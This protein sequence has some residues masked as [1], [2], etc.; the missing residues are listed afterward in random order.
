MSL[1]DTKP[2]VRQH[3]RTRRRAANQ[4][5]GAFEEAARV[6]ESRWPE[7]AHAIRALKANLC[8]MSMCKRRGVSNK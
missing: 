5:D 2:R 8:G 6:V 7:A 3:G 1:D 4:R